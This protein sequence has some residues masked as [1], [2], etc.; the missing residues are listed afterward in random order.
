[1][2]KKGKII[3]VHNFFFNKSQIK[4]V[5]FLNYNAECKMLLQ[6]FYFQSRKNAS[7]FYQ[8]YTYFAHENILF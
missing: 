4:M 2:I 5:S 7:E 1:M 3:N 6:L 8:Y